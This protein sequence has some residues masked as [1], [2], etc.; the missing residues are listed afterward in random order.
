MNTRQIRKLGIPE[1][2]V[3]VAIKAIQQLRAVKNSRK[4]QIRQQLQSVV[5]DPESFLSDPELGELASSLI[6][7]RDFV[8]PQPVAYQVWGD[9]Q[10]DQAA[11]RQMNQACH[12]P[13]AVRGALMPDAHVGYGLP[14]GGVLACR[15]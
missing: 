5:E 14:I 13:V 12:V 11:H 8:P 1:D 10:I 4:N 6:Q 7:E 3:G 9:D 15:N 2:S